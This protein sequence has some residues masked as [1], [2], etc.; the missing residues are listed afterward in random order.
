M[1]LNLET[2][3]SNTLLK[4]G[5]KY[6]RDLG[7]KT[8]SF[9]SLGLQCELTILDEGNSQKYSI[10]DLISQ[11]I[12][13][14]DPIALLGGPGAGKST[15]LLKLANLFSEFEVDEQQY[16][17]IYIRCGLNAGTEIKNQIHLSGFTKKEK[18][19]LWES[20]RLCIIFDGIN[21]ISHTS[22]GDYLNEIMHL[23]EE[24]PC[25]YIVSCRT[26]EFPRF[27]NKFFKKYR[28]LPV[29][30]QQIEHKLKSDLGEKSGDFYYNSL[31]HG[32]QNYLLDICRNP[33]LLS[34]VSKIIVENRAKNEEFDLSQLRTRG[35]IYEHFCRLLIDHQVSKKDDSDYEKFSVLREELIK[36]IAYYMQATNQVYIDDRTLVKII[37]DMNYLEDRSKD[38]IRNLQVHNS[39]NLWYLA[40]KKDLKKSSF[41]NGYVQS[42]TEYFSFIHQS[43]QEYFAGVYISIHADDPAYTTYLLPKHPNSNSKDSQQL[44]V[45]RNWGAI[46][47]AANLDATNRIIKHTMRY[48]RETEDSDTL[49]L[50]AKCIFDRE[51]VQCPT[52]MADDCCIWMLEAFKYW[53]LPYK[54]DLIYAANELMP[55]V[56]PD[57]PKR[58]AQDIEYFGEKYTGGHI[59]SEYPESFD[60]EHLRTIIADGK[61]AYQLNAIYSLGERS[62]GS[63]GVGTVLQFLFS[64]LD[65]NDM[66][67][68]EQVVKALK[69]LIENNKNA[70]LSGAQ[71]DI[72]R[73]IISDKEES[74]RIRTYA[75][76]TI[77]EVGDKDAIQTVMDYLKDKENP[78][79]DSASWSLQELVK[80]GEHPYTIEFMQKF[81]YDCLIDETA[82]QIGMYSKGNLVYTLSKLRATA[83]IP[84]LKQWIKR[85]TEP[86][87]QE[88]GINTIGALVDCN[89]IAFIKEY[90]HSIDPVIRSKAY[91]CLVNLGYKFSQE[92]RDRIQDDPYSI[93]NFIVEDKLN[94]PGTDVNTLLKFSPDNNCKSSIQQYYENVRT[95]INKIEKS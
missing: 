69:R 93:V 72:L 62:W 25:K 1:A 28:V 84:K 87:V 61:Y 31:M 41:F 76:N 58:L 67:L 95:V 9:I 65:S 63:N 48:A 60:F 82:D 56:N 26:M 17:P 12:H 40:I 18:E 32:S 19:Q 94:I 45:K 46:E 5:S 53:H 35:D 90:T 50:A 92:E 75:L 23:S 79:R 27:A 47:F 78:Y 89:E 66:N 6:S 52:H 15:L 91:R 2:K 68:R 59:S 20:G 42:G 38:L 30:D 49:V 24:Y 81:Y 14:E 85:E 11:I 36:T 13:S 71:L 16:I 43:F 83:Y 88:D 4:L 64:L 7:E 39:D 21:E 34:L 10:E 73:K 8:S 3:I 54:Y 51:T 37:R 22:V 80:G 70:E 86:Y 33:L 44:K 74:A 29:T 57:F 77:A 55:F